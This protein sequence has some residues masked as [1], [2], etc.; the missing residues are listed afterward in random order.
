MYEGSGVAVALAGYR[1]VGKSHFMAVFAALTGTPE[2]R[3]KVSDSHVAAAAQ[4]L[5]RRRYPIVQV[6]RGTEPTLLDELR[7]A[8]ANALGVSG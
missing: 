4:G 2:L 6:R 7:T 5:L 8:F 3:T 1:G